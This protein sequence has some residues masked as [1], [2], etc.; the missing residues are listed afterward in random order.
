MNILKSDAN[1]SNGN[2]AKSE[3]ESKDTSNKKPQEA[4]SKDF[5]RQTITTTT[6]LAVINSA[7]ELL[8]THNTPI[9]VESV[10]KVACQLEKWALGGE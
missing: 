7:I 6:R 8:K 3:V 1:G 10:F 4:H 5:N 2:G 9:T